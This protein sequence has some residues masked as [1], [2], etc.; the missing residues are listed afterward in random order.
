LR[1]EH[2]VE[3][4]GD[5]ERLQLVA[6]RVV[7]ERGQLKALPAA[8]FQEFNETTVAEATEDRER[9]PFHPAFDA[10]L[11]DGPIEV[12]AGAGAGE[13]R[14]GDIGGRRVSQRLLR[15]PVGAQRPDGSPAFERPH[16]VRAEQAEQHRP[17]QR[18][19]AIQRPVDIEHDGLEPL[20][21]E[22]KCSHSEIWVRLQ[23]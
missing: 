4:V 21:A 11:H 17:A 15:V 9:L 12:R 22:W 13:L 8:R 20:G 16:S 18:R 3:A 23:Q 1:A 5:S 10:L 2:E 19:L 14:F 6:R 7:G